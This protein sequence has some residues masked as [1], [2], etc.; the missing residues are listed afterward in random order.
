MADFF[1]NNFF[2]TC[3]LKP[4]LPILLIAFIVLILAFTSLLL[5]QLL[6]LL[7]PLASV[8]FSSCC[9]LNHSHC[10]FTENAVSL[11]CVSYPQ[12]YSC[13]NRRRI[14]EFCVVEKHPFG[15][16]LNSGRKKV[17]LITECYSLFSFVLNTKKQNIL[18]CF[19]MR[20]SSERKRLEASSEHFN[21]ILTY[22]LLARLKMCSFQRNQE[23]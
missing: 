9:Y 2:K 19:V 17:K 10:I 8:A 16:L 14:T 6:L 21:M 3:V 20:E 23:R 1:Y 12:P 4:C 7:L 13:S 11:L 22:C 18:V 15:F 5:H